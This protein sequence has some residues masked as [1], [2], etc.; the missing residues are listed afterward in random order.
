M[1]ALS[2]VALPFFFSF[3]IVVKILFGEKNADRWIPTVA[4]MDDLPSWV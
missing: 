4:K 1:E 2:V 3:W